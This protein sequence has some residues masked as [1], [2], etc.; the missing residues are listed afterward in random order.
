MS[1][2]DRPES[3]ARPLRIPHDIAVRSRTSGMA[4]APYPLMENQEAI[5]CGI[6]IFGTDMAR[7][8][9]W[10]FYC[11]PYGALEEHRW[12]WRMRVHGVTLEHSL[13][14]F[15]T[16]GQCH[17]DALD[18]GFAGSFQFT[19]ENVAGSIPAS[20]YR[21]LVRSRSSKH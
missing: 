1:L 18:H 7:D 11:T 10:E 17:K 5:S 6:S 20:A 4:L 2:A 15:E 21:D 13:R 14:M 8:L 3:P 16:F 12:G 9:E 19:G